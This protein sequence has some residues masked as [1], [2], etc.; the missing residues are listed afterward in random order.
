MEAEKKKR[1]E[2]EKLDKLFQESSKR[3]KYAVTD[4]EKVFLIHCFLI[5]NSCSLGPIDSGLLFCF[6]PFLPF[7]ASCVILFWKL[8][9][10]WHNM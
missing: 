10:K 1:N 3:E 9:D 5:F 2:E 8:W 4:E 7:A 6:A